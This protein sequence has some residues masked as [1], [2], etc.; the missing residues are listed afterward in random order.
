MSQPIVY[1][2]KQTKESFGWSERFKQ[3]E[4][5]KEKTKTLACTQFTI[6]PLL[7]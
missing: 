2:T 1:T 3:G 7:S 6:N 4:N 5:D